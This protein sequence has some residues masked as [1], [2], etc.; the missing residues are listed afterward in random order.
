MNE[1]LWHTQKKKS[2][3]VICTF[4][5]GERKH[6]AQN[7]RENQKQRREREIQEVRKT[8]G[9]KGRQGRMKQGRNKGT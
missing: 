2:K 7:C 4:L 1:S 6:K 3:I 9:T 5:D 8:G